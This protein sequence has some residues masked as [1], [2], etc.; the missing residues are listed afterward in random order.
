MVVESGSKSLVSGF[1]EFGGRWV[2]RD[3]VV[4]MVFDKAA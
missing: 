4:E 2:E 3:D 1:S